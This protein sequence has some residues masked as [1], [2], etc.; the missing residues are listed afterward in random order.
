MAHAPVF[1]ELDALLVSPE[2]ME[3]P[4][5]IYTRLR[6]EAPVFWSEQWQAWVVSRYD[7]V[8]A[9][10]KDKE[11][12]SN[13]NRQAL[14]FDG[15]TDKERE[16]LSL[17]RHYFSQKDVIGS[18]APDH[19]RMRALVQKTFTPKRVASLEPHVRALAVSMIEEGK[20]QGGF[21]FVSEVAHP[22][23][24]VL[25]A[26]MLGVPAEDRHLFKRWSSD[27]LGFQGTG[28]TA[29]GPAMVS[30]TSLVEMFDY[31]N[32]L[33]DS[34]RSSPKDDI[35]TALALAEE[36]GQQFSRAELLAT[37]NTLL[38]AGH[39]TTTNLIGNL[40]HL[41]LTHPDQWRQLQRQPA[42][43]PSA[44]EEALRFEAPKQRNF[45][46]IKRS[47]IF[48][49]LPFE[50]NQM[51]FQL[52][53]AA[54]RDPLKFNNA[55]AFDITRQRN[56]HLSFGAGIHFCLGASLARI[57]ARIVLERLIAAIPN[58]RLD[59]QSLL[60]QDRVQFRGPKELWISGI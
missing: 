7:D 19:T 17:L 49:G 47:H 36:D 48:G 29:F 1:P 60:W 22:L 53:G 55:D 24:V 11:N 26:E 38:T 5:P 33:I 25:I 58:C 56:E 59:Q 32:L 54:N 50:E 51:V 15:L 44:I 23:P 10:L 57:E 46:R 41:L 8:A 28:R 2:I 20:K 21:D 9:S 27:I 12:L 3:N 34:R 35:I 6:D 42:L 40:V 14:L 43:L 52:I 4:Y 13:E 45:R 39:E 31:M 18:D 16:T 37:C 30:Q